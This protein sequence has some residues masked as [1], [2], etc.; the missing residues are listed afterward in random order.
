MAS[1]VGLRVCF[2]VRVCVMRGKIYLQCLIGNEL[3][4]DVLVVVLT[5]ACISLNALLMLLSEAAEYHHSYFNI[6]YSQSLARV[7][8]QTVR[9]K[10]MCFGAYVKCPFLVVCGESVLH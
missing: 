3:A 9:N 10:T 7:K 6:L 5:R 1:F 8:V 4:C 2:W